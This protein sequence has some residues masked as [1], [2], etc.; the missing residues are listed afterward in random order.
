MTSSC[1]DEDAERL[2]SLGRTEEAAE[3]EGGRPFPWL[4][5]GSGKVNPCFSS[6]QM[7]VSQSSSLI[8]QPWRQLDLDSWISVCLGFLIWNIGINIQ[9]LWSCENLKRSRRHL[10]ELLAGTCKVYTQTGWSPLS[11]RWNEGSRATKRCPFKN[12]G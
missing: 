4:V 6:H 9:T 12:R 5:G 3:A 10:A 7:Q 1:A 11:C 8:S 2:S